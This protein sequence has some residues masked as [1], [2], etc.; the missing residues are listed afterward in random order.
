MK[1]LFGCLAPV[2]IVGV[3][4]SEGPAWQAPLPAEGDDS[5]VV[6]PKVKE[7]HKPGNHQKYPG[8]CWL[9]RLSAPPTATA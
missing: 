1:V 5:P 8:N 3:A 7:Y 2:L 4:P 9:T 6:R